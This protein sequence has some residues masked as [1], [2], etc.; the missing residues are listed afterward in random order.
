MAW[1]NA[2]NTELARLVQEYGTR[3]LFIL[4][5][6]DPDV[7]KPVV[8]E[9]WLKIAKLTMD[10]A[11]NLKGRKVGLL[12]TGPTLGKAAREGVTTGDLGP[13]MRMAQVADEKRAPK[14][15]VVTR[16]RAKGVLILVVTGITTTMAHMF[17]SG[18]KPAAKAALEAPCT[19]WVGGK[20]KKLRSHVKLWALGQRACYTVDAMQELV[21]G[22]ETCW[23]LEVQITAITDDH[24]P[25][26][27]DFYVHGDGG[28]GS[29]NC[30]SSANLDQAHTS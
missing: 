29:G 7:A 15:L 18:I 25:T 20:Q 4:Y 5:R 11:V 22:D 28:G 24:L 19:Y 21:A 16:V 9:I 23:T 27:S 8:V 3:D 1:E 12:G 10:G 17:A 13:W 26:E 2:T 14:G 30:G 6:S